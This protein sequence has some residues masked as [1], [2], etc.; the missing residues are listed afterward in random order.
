MTKGGALVSRIRIEAM[1]TARIPN[2][3]TAQGVAR[4]L[5]VKLGA[6]F[7]DDTPEDMTFILWRLRV[8]VKRKTLLRLAK[9]GNLVYY[10]YQIPDR[11]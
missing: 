8:S 2:P 10:G 6:E 11:S 7:V 1:E 5:N 3:M 9:H 4:C